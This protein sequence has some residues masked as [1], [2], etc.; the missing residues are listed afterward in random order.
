MSEANSANGA[1]G[2]SSGSSSNG[3]APLIGLSALQRYVQRQD[4]AMAVAEAV[5]AGALTFNRIHASNTDPAEDLEYEGTPDN[6]FSQTAL[7]P[8]WEVPGESACTAKIRALAEEAISTHP[9]TLDAAEA[10]AGAPAASGHVL[11]R[12][13]LEN[14]SKLMFKHHKMKHEPVEWLYDGVGPLLLPEVLETGK[15]VPLTL[16]IA[17]QSVARRLGVPTLLFN[18][19]TGG[20]QEHRHQQRCVIRMGVVV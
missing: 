10:G 5:E 7:D 19:T 4:L 14:I 15:G 3:P 12:S 1:L 6:G 8:L 20:V 9:S 13:Q 11:L 17:H 16:A 18:A 2:S